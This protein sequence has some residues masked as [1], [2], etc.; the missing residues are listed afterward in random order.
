MAARATTRR[1]WGWFD[2]AAKQGHAGATF[3]LGALYGGGHDIP[4]DRS[5]ALEY[6]ATAAEKGH[7]VAQLMLGRYHARGLAGPKDLGQAR[8]WLERARAQGV[9]DAIAEL[10]ALPDEA[11]SDASIAS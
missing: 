1:R 3:A 6:F 8:L 11:L 7:G 10:K 2:A 5:L 4:V 9:A